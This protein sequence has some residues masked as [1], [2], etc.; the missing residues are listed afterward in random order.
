MEQF[1]IALSIHVKK[2]FC[3]FLFFVA[4]YFLYNGFICFHD[5]WFTVFC[6]FSTI[7]QSD[8]VTHTDIHSFFSL[9]MFHHKLLDIV[10]SATEILIHEFFVPS[11]PSSSSSIYHVIQ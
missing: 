5:S 4:I 11:L 1:A 3:F 8:L 10:P 2:F 7:Q 9:I 6:Q